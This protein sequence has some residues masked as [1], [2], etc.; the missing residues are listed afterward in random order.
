MPW[1]HRAGVEERACQEKPHREYIIV[2][3][4]LNDFGC[5]KMGVQFS[6]TLGT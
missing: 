2:G 3:S 6:V 1:Q 5:E 4:P